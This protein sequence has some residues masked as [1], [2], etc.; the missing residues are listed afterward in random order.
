MR[1]RVAVSLRKTLN[2]ISYLGVRQSIPVVVAQPDERHAKRTA[3]VLEWYAIH[4]DSTT[5]GSNEEEVKSNQQ[6]CYIS[7]FEY[8]VIFHK[9]TCSFLNVS[10]LSFDQNTLQ[11]VCIQKTNSH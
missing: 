6:E 3:S 8:C 11:M 9:E 4:R 5:S 7:L 2:A 1:W 10:H